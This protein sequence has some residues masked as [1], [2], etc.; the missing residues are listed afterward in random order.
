M[1]QVLR[2][3]N[4]SGKD[5]AMRAVRENIISLDLK[6]GSH[7]SANNLTE[8]FGLSRGPI[9]EALSELSKTG[10][11]EVY[12]QSGC[13][14]S[15][16]NEE[17]INEARFMRKSLECSV[18]RE[19]ALKASEKE[20]L[21]LE[22]NIALQEFY[23]EKNMSNKLLEADD[24]FHQKLFD[25]ANMQNVYKL[26]KDFVIH[27]DRLRSLTL[28]TIKVIKVVEDHKNILEAVR[29]KDSE[30][31]GELMMKHLSRDGYNIKDL[32]AAHPEYFVSVK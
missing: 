6:P 16:I 24:W 12:P 20:I 31:A 21:E 28:I 5:Y 8:A 17:L 18:A 22:E 4:E 2:L 9:R 27:L 14:I 29:S 15:L 26:M 23:L 25:I 3:V 1:K 10:I 32:K 11:V 7:I 19:A 30:L 13:K